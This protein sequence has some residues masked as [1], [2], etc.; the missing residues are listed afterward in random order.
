MSGITDLQKNLWFL[1][2]LCMVCGFICSSNVLCQSDDPK[3]G[4]HGFIVKP[5]NY[6]PMTQNAESQ[7]GKDIF[8]NNSCAMCHSI[9]GQGGCLAP[10]LDGIGAYRSREFILSRITR[11]PTAEEK[12]ARLYG[13]AELMPH[14]R[15]AAK[16]ARLVVQYLLTLP[17]PDNGFFVSKHETDPQPRQS[18]E[19]HRNHA[20]TDTI[21]INQGKEL[22]Y[23]HGCI[24]CHTIHD[25]GGHFAPTFDNISK[26]HSEDYIRQRITNVEFFA[27]NNDDEYGAR[28]TV[29][30]PSNLTSTEIEK[31]SEYLMSLK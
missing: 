14:V 4:Q 29:M 18:I 31:I 21:A 8:A 13:K 9:N 1:L 26:R 2:F 30:P 16:D 17:A 7:I 19:K 15:I 28:G 3:Q 23:Q 25:I 20:S 27:Q 6:K 24:A 12:F 22:V 10:P 11:G 5:N